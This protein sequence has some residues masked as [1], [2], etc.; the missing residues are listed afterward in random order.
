MVSKERLMA[1]LAKQNPKLE[2]I[3]IRGLVKSKETE[4]SFR[5]TYRAENDDFLSISDIVKYDSVKRKIIADK[6]EKQISKNKNKVK[7][8]K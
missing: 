3:G 8:G 6:K 1:I 2:I 7:N 5:F 4:W